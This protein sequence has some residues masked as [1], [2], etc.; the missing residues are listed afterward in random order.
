PDPSEKWT[1]FAEPMLAEVMV[2]GPDRVAIGSEAVYDVYVDFKG[3][4]YPSDDI[5]QVR[6]LV[7]DATGELAV[8]GD[9]EAAGEGLYEIVLDADL[10]SGLAAGSNRL[11]VVVVS[12]RVAVPSTDALLFVTQ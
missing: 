5:E 9:A 10:T 8:V 12:K 6:Y 1:G 4:P 2:D 7:F 11:E 3:K